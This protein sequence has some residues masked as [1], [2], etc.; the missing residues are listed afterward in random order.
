MDLDAKAERIVIGGIGHATMPARG[1]PCV[2][3]TPRDTQVTPSSRSMSPNSA[4]RKRPKPG[5][6]VPDDFAAALAASPPARVH[7]DGFTDA[8]RRDYLEWIVGA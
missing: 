5:I 7:F 4:A 3:P 1:P 6:P 8:Q 2:G